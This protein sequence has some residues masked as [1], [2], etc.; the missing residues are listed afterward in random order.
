MVAVPHSPLDVSL[1]EIDRDLAAIIEKANR[2][3]ESIQAAQATQTEVLPS[4]PTLFD[5]AP[6]LFDAD[7]VVARRENEVADTDSNAPLLV[8]VL[9]L[10][11]E[12][13]LRAL[14]L[15]TVAAMAW[16]WMW[17]IGEGHGR[18]SMPTVIVTTLFAWASLLSVY[19]L[20]FVA[21]MTKP[22]PE[23]APPRLRVAMVV[24]KAPSEPFSVVQKTLRAMLH[25]RF[26]YAYDVWLADERP[27]EETLRWCAAREVKVCSRFGV[28]EYHQPAW[29]RRTK[30]KEGNLAYFYDT[31]GYDNYDVVAQLDADHVPTR[32]YLAHMVRPFRDPKVGYVSAPSI[33]DANDE[34]GWT[35]KG[36]LFREAT[37][38]GPVQAGSNEGYAPVCIGSHYAVRTAALKEVGGLGPELAEDYT[39]TLWLQSGGWDGVFS[40]EAEAHGDGPD[41]LAEMLT[42]EVQWA[43]SLG[44]VLVRYAPDKLRTVPLKARIRLGFALLF[45]PLQGVALALGAILPTIG[46][47]ARVTWGNTTLA[48]FYG[49]IWPMSLAGLA[50]TAYLRRQKLLR[51]T[52]AKLWSWE[53]LLFQL[54]RWP[55]AMVGAVQGIRAGLSEQERAFKVT[56]KGERGLK[57]LPARMLLPSLLVGAIPA[58]VAIMTHN[59]GIAVGLFVLASMQA[60]TYLVAVAIAVA[61]HARNNARVQLDVSPG[62]VERVRLLAGDT[63]LLTAGF[64]LLTIGALSLRLA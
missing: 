63:A 4:A 60:L 29:P 51:P 30:C 53:L 48:A 16:F 46:V 6:T 31:V 44:T 28:D 39:T 24:T 25:Q 14:V 15:A 45:Y 21:R 57:P 8:P 3:R 10:R 56:P 42:Q 9:P 59:P 38:H 2:L 35:V 20:F 22:N 11:K 55:W 7:V 13:T 12:L 36:R 64:A 43:R 32:D 50:T 41:G 17:W 40:I 49:H 52:N 19:F 26:P 27:D 5:P 58:W 34:K 37:L 23:L 62:P 54:I 33:C 1:A 61:I 47:L 18:W